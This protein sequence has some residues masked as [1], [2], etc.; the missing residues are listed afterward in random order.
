MNLLQL[1]FQLVDG[2][3]S[4]VIGHHDGFHIGHRDL[5]NTAIKPSEKIRKTSM[6][7]S[8]RRIELSHFVVERPDADG[9]LKYATDAGQLL[10]MSRTAHLWLPVANPGSSRSAMIDRIDR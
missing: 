10:A 2:G 6:L 9:N 8:K 1:R 7:C 3:V 5:S 4:R